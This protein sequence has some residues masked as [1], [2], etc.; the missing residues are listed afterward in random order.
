MNI[1]LLIHMVCDHSRHFF[2][3]PFSLACAANKKLSL[4]LYH[5]AN[6]PS[7]GLYHV[8]DHVTRTIPKLIGVKVSHI[9]WV[10]FF[11]LFLSQLTHVAVLRSTLSN[12]K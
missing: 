3:F 10:L 12:R 11:F 6:E 2:F 8:N 1:N 9:A 4:V 5:L 7:V